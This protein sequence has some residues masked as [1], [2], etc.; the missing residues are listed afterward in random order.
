MQS[1]LFATGQGAFLTGSAVFFTHIVGLSATQVGL[2]LTVAGA[3]TFCLAIPLG[4]LADR[5]G[6]KQMWALGASAGAALYLLWP[7]ITNFATFLAMMVAL[8]PLARTQQPS[9][10]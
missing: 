9:T 5:I 10:A 7:F 6:P 3:V 1:V 4:K 8:K 2:G